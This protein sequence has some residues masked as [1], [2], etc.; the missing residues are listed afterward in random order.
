MLGSLPAR[1]ARCLLSG[2][3]LGLALASGACHPL[4]PCTECPDVAGTYE[5]R[6]TPIDPVSSTGGASAGCAAVAFPGV[7]DTLEIGQDGKLPS[8][9]STGGWIDLSGVLY[10]DASFILGP[11]D[12]QQTSAGLL[13]ITLTGRF[14]ETK[15]GYVSDGEVRLELATEPCD[16]RT[17]LQL[18]QLTNGG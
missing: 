14:L 15:N 8:R 16:L 4:E 6:A 3:L 17:P 5:M 18:R 2:S 13:R 10:Q 11:A 9:L 7:H 12:Y 1:L